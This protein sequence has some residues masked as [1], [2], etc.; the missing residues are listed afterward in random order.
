M[1]GAQRL[2]NGGT[3][4]GKCLAVAPCLTFSASIPLG[5]WWRVVVMVVMV[6]VVVVVVVLRKVVVIVMMM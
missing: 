5:T 1:S 3:P 6:K 2:P 4:F